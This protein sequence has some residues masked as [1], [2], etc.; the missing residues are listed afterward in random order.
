MASSGSNGVPQQGPG[1]FRQSGP[2]VPSFGYPAQ[3][4][5]FGP[6][7]PVFAQMNPG[8]NFPISNPGADY[9]PPAQPN[10]VI[11]KEEPMEGT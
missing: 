11:V 3:P 6:G 4:S 8:Q 7:G 2:Y 1:C 9:Q 5:V 10:A